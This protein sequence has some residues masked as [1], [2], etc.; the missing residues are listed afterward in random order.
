MGAELKNTIALGCAGSVVLSPHVGDMET[1]EAVD[2]LQAVVDA[3]PD[4]LGRTPEV[5][6]VDA[7]PD[8]HATRHGRALAARAGLPVVE[9]QHHVAHAAACL[10]ENGCAEGLALAFD[11]TGLG[12]DGSIWGAELIAWSPDRWERLATFAPVPLPGGDAAVMHPERQWVARRFAAGVK[13]PA[14]V[15]RAAGVDPDDAEIW[16]EQ[17]RRG[18]N[19]PLTHAAGRLFDAFAA[20]LGLLPRG[21]ITY[22]AQGPIRLEAAAARAGTARSVPYSTRESGGMLLVDWGEPFR[23]LAPEAVRCDRNAWAL[24]LHEAVARAA[25]EMIEYGFARHSGRVV[26]LTGGVFMNRLLHERLVARITGAGAR[27]ALHRMTPPNDGCVAFGQAVA[28]GR[29]DGRQ[30]NDDGSADNRR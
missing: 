22:E 7:H 26:A 12:T 6:A 14:A 10:A 23:A 17:C 25:M 19:A 16:V 24:G 1:P 8:M 21:G 30:H 29:P 27:V 2:G 18:I 9:V 15:A 20:L 5:V 11:G 28:A 4:F 13:D 3:L